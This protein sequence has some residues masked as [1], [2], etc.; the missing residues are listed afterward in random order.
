MAKSKS[1][2]EK[3]A[4]LFMPELGLSEEEYNE[5]A[6]KIGE[7]FELCLAGKVQTGKTVPTLLW[8]QV[9]ASSKVE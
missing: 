3:E 8:H 7:T 4:N 9:A 2:T 1:Y 6:Q 5:I